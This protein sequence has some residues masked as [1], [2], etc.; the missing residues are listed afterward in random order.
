MAV[1]IEGMLPRSWS[2]DLSALS[3]EERIV[4]LES[5]IQLLSDAIG[6][7]FVLFVIACMLVYT[8]WKRQ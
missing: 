8:F 2:A 3:L 6:W 4:L 5:E 7:L 1:D